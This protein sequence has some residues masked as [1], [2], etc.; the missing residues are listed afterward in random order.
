[1][2]EQPC[3]RPSPTGDRGLAPVIPLRRRAAAEP[4]EA[5]REPTPVHRSLH[6]DLVRLHE[7]ER[8]AEALTDPVARI[9]LTAVVDEA[10]ARVL[11]AAFPGPAPRRQGRADAAPRRAARPRALRGS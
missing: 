3:R 2:A 7:M 1:M 10:F 5:G 4:S 9:R 8:L 11:E 6:D